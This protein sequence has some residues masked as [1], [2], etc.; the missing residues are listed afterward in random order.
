MEKP[1][2]SEA[3]QQEL[4][5]IACEHLFLDTLETR[6]SG[7]DFKEQAVWCIR[8]ALEAAYLAGMAVGY[9]IAD[10]V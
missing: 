9:R 5:R 2:F 10:R 1:K 4:S 3:A 8:D 7:E 6:R